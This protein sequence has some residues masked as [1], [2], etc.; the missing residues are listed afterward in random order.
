MNKTNRSNIIELPTDE[1][2]QQILDEAFKDADFAAKSLG[3]EIPN[4]DYT[5][6]LKNF[7]N[8]RL[9]TMTAE[10]TFKLKEE[11]SENPK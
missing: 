7:E 4:N 8:L 5:L 9:P 2:I 11:V 3:F 1:M 6:I 10:R